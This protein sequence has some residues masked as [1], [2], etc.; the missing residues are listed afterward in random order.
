MTVAPEMKM[1]ERVNCSKF[2]Q[3]R[4]QANCRMTI[5]GFLITHITILSEITDFVLFKTGR[6]FIF[7]A[8]LRLQANIQVVQLLV[9]HG[10]Y[11][12]LYLSPDNWKES[13][14]D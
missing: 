8:Q 2:H 6:N 9:F 3:A 13:H 1:T 5:D 10:L 11:N 12:L 7:C 4:S 14:L